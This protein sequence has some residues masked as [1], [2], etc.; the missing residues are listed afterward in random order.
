MRRQRTP[1]RRGVLCPGPALV[2]APVIGGRRRSDTTDTSS[3]RETGDPSERADHPRP[4]DPAGALAP[5]AGDG[6]RR[7][8]LQPAAARAHHLPRLRGR[9]RQR[10][11]DLRAAAAARG[12]RPR[13]GHLAVHQLARRLGVGRHGDLRHHAVRQ[14]R[15]RDGVD[16]P[17]RLDGAVPALRRPPGQALRPAARADHD[18]PAVRWPRRHRLRHPDPGRAD[19]LHQEEDGRADRPAHRPDGRDHRAD[20][21]RDRWFTAEDAKDYGLVDQVVASAGQVAGSGGTA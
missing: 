9:G 18:A 16:G 15:R 6:P 1:A 19:A 2:S 14:E 8:G 5:A 7:P 21:D 17:G 3:R 4:R 13:Q 10:Q 11:R 12:G 20:S